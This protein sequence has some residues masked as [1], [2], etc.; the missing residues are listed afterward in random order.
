MLEHLNLTKRETEIL[1]YISQG[2]A[3]KDVAFLCNISPRTVQKHVENIYTKLGVETRNA[4]ML[5]AF[6]NL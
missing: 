5:K 2:K 4:A 6:E 3:N 1:F